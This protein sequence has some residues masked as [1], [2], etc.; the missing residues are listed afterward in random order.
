MKRT[1]PSAGR[2]TSDESGRDARQDSVACRAG[3]LGSALLDVRAVV[4]ASLA[5]ALATAR[6]L[7]AG[8]HR[9]VGVVDPDGDKAQAR[10]W[11]HSRGRVVVQQKQWLRALIN[12]CFAVEHL[13]V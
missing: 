10:P 11:H 8:F 2:A 4:G 12:G 5:S 9:G 1:Q 13:E 6:C 7:R 3:S